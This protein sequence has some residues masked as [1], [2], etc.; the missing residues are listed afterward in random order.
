MKTAV[1]WNPTSGNADEALLQ[2]TFADWHKTELVSTLQPGDGGKLARQ[3]VEQGAKRIIAVGGD[4]TIGEIVN[5]LVDVLDRVRLGILPAGTGNDLA[6][7]LGIPLEWD[8]AVEVLHQSHRQHFDLIRV[9]HQGESLRHFLNVSVGGFTQE[10]K[11]RAEEN[12]KE[13]WGPLGYLEAGLEGSA[14][15]TPYKV[16]ITCDDKPST[17]MEASIVV[18][19][20]SPYMSAGIPIVPGARPND[21][22][23]DF[24]AFRPCNA[25]EL[26]VLAPWVLTGQHTESDW[27]VHLQAKS[28]TLRSEPLMP[29]DMDD[30]YVTQPELTFEALHQAIEIYVPTRDPNEEDLLFHGDRVLM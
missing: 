13:N 29:F 20:N 7:G 16:R 10:V 9:H 23:V 12:F 26:M 6:R 24:L 8:E 22:K 5:G 30:R 18:M 11:E 4:G 17:T 21:G 19:A 15:I 25:A 14:H 2:Q 1:I 27:V 28:V 3:A